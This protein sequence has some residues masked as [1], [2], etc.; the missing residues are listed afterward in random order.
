MISRVN[1]LGLMLLPAL[2]G[3]YTSSINTDVTA[4]ANAHF[5]ESEQETE[6][7]LGVYH[8][9]LVRLWADKPEYV[10]LLGK[11]HR[12][13]PRL[14]SAAVPKYPLVLAIARVEATV[15]VSFVIGPDGSV[16]AA[17][18]IE[19]SDSRFDASALEAMFKTSFLPA[20]GPDGPERDVELQPIHFRPRGKPQNGPAT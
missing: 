2:S 15:V 20:E 19:S 8:D 11:K 14:L 13:E 7:H 5:E 16:E 12:R 4:R 1:W 9:R 3:C 10:A 18:V 17:R 6:G